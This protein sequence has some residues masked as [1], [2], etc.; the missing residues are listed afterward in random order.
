[1]RVPFTADEFFDVFRR[2][3][4]AIWPNQSLLFLLA[5]L[6][7]IVVAAGGRNGRSVT[8]TLGFLWLWMAFAYHFAFFRKI[9]PAA[10]GFAALF[11]VE[12][13]L[14]IVSGARQPFLVFRLRR[15]FAGAMGAVVVGYALVVYPVLG[16][17][18]GQRYLGAPTFGLPCPTTIFTL[19]ILMWGQRTGV[20]K[21]AVVPLLWAII[22]TQAAFA[23]GVWEDLGLSVAAVLFVTSLWA[24]RRTATAHSV[25]SQ[26][27]TR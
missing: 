25:S 16:Y 22:A 10:V 26:L 2:Y 1:M 11:A 27:L 14:L 9:N 20:Q 7:V 24:I 6:A 23:L 15:D 21:L 12:G 3:N 19:G 17:A 8:A 13:I 5:L 18:L 4:E